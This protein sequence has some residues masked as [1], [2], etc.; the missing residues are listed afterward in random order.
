MVTICTA[1]I[2]IQKILRSFPHS[3]FMCFVWIWEQTAIISL[4]SINWLVS[5]TEKECAYCAVRTEYLYIELTLILTFKCPLMAQAVTRRSVALE[6]RVRSQFIPCE[7]CGGQSDI[8]TDFFSSVSIFPV[9]IIPPILHVHLYL[10]VALTKRTNG[11][12]L[13]TVQQAMLFRK[14][15][16]FET[17]LSH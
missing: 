6:G 11:R 9:S 13:G 10:F 5:I 2:N 14:S 15:G 16:S 7:I 4:Y 12:S 1:R 8:G 17:S 3:I